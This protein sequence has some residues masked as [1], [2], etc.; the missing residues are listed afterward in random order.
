MPGRCRWWSFGRN[1]LGDNLSKVDSPRVNTLAVVGFGILLGLLFGGLIRQQ[2]PDMLA[3]NVAVWAAFA[4]TLTLYTLAIINRA[5]GVGLMANMTQ[6][7]IIVLV[8]PLAL[9]FLVLGTIFVGIATPTEGGAMGA[10][11][12]LL[13]ASAKRR[14]SMDLLRQAHGRRP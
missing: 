11:G 10:A 5:T 7:V 6:Q 2:R 12:A 1:L 4:A 14:L 3:D 9:I 13:L 8:P